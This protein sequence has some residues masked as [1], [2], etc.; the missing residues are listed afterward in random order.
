LDT[1]KK[2]TEIAY[3]F[4][5]RVLM[6]TLYERL[7]KGVVSVLNNS[8]RDA[9]KDFIEAFEKIDKEMAEEI[10][11]RMFVFEDLALL[12]DRSVQKMLKEVDMTELAKALKGV[13]TEVQDKI[14]TNMSDRASGLLKEDIVNVGPV[15]LKDVEEMQQRIVSI[16]LRL[17][18]RG[19]ITVERD[20]AR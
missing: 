8:S 7:I 19:E 12:A 3:A 9:E 2:V 5:R 20:L 1:E 14:F 11:K 18:E 16:I 10:K 15:R 13:Q 6:E 4:L 17:E